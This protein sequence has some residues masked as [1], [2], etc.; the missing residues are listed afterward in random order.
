V[1]APTLPDFTLPVASSRDPLGHA[2]AL[3]LLGRAVEVLD[4]DLATASRRPHLYVVSVTCALGHPPLFG[5]DDLDGISRD[6]FTRDQ[7]RPLALRLTA[8]RVVDPAEGFA[9]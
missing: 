8:A 5:V 7:L 4:A 2:A 9:P 1:T 6:G 3:A